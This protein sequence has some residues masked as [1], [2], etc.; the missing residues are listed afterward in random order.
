MAYEWYWM[1]FHVLICHLYIFFG[2]MSVHVFCPSL[3]GSFPY[4]WVLRVL[5]I[6]QIQVDR[7]ISS[8]QSLS[9]VRLFATP[10]IAARQASLFITNSQSSLKLKSIK[11][12]MPSSHLI[13]CHPLFLLPP[14]PPSTTIYFHCQIQSQLDV[15]TLAQPLHSFCSHFLAL[16]Q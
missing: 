11:L 13:L 2:E 1:S 9:R 7:W 16:P 12:V 14:I 15:S 10:W 6:F 8:V 3:I 5:Y 4:C